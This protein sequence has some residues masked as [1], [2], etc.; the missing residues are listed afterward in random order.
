MWWMNNFSK[1]KALWQIYSHCL[2]FIYTCFCTPFGVSQVVCGLP[3]FLLASEL[4]DCFC[5]KCCIGGESALHANC[6][7]AST[8]QHQVQGCNYQMWCFQ[9]DMARTQ[10]TSLGGTCSSNCTT[11]QFKLLVVLHVQVTVAL[12]SSSY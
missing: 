1:I 2:S 10:S 6:F 8:H 3:P 12:A 4:H 7:F 9:Y 5:S 11:G